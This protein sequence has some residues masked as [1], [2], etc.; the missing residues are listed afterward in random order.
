MVTGTRKTEENNLSTGIRIPVGVSFPE[1]G[2]GGKSYGK[3]KKNVGEKGSL[4]RVWAVRERSG[5][6]SRYKRTQSG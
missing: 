2:A 4:E 6:R 5:N 3:R 1:L